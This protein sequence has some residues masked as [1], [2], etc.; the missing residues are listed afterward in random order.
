MLDNPSRGI[1]ADGS[2]LSSSDKRVHVGLGRA[3]MAGSVTVRWPDGHLDHYAD[4]AGDRGYVVREGGKT[5][6]SRPGRRA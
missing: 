5:L 1:Y 6:D 3:K 2:Y 4:V